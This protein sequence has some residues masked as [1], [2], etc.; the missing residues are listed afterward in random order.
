MIKFNSLSNSI[1]SFSYFN[2]VTNGNFNGTM[3]WDAGTGTGTSTLSEA[4]NILTI[5]GTGAGS[6][7]RASQTTSVKLI[8]NKKILIRATLK[9]LNSTAIVVFLS[10]TDNTFTTRGTYQG[11]R[12]VNNP[13]ENTEY[14]FNAVLTVASGYDAIDGRIYIAHQYSSAV[15]ST[16]KT[17]EVKEV[18]AIDLTSLYGAGNEPSAADCENIFR[19]VDGTK[20]PNFSNQIAT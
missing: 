3:N 2:F 7:P 12:T 16:G 19:F 6:T 8:A 4:S 15:N 11:T 1:D 20:Q 9:V 17:M 5:S 13:T 14:K 18:L 10:F